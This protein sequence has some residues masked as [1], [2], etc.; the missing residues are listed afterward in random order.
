MLGNYP[1]C[2]LL[3][4]LYTVNN[5]LYILYL[6]KFLS[7][8]SYLYISLGVKTGKVF[9]INLLLFNPIR[10]SEGDSC[11]KVIEAGKSKFDRRST[12][13]FFYRS[14]RRHHVRIGHSSEIVLDGNLLIFFKYTIKRSD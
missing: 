8:K 2:N 12:D 9:K 1:P 14:Y 7:L 10:L 5:I 3:Y 11:V 6:M 13:R 4:R